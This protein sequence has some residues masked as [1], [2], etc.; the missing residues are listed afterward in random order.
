[1]IQELQERRGT[2]IG[3]NS[4]HWCESMQPAR[5]ESLRGVAAAADECDAFAS[6]NFVAAEDPSD[7]PAALED[8]T[9]E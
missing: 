5:M 4:T 6:S 1:M 3:W 8:V 7:A 9:A 2:G